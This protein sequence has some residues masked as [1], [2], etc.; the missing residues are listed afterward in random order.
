MSLFGA[1]TKVLLA[2]VTIAA[3]VITLGGAMNERHQPYTVSLLE[4]IGDEIEDSLD[5]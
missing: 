2:P 4:D 1:L 5:N 3:D